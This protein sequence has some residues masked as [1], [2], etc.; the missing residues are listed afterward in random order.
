MPNEIM[1]NAVS[2]TDNSRILKKAFMIGPSKAVIQKGTIEVKPVSVAQNST[3]NQTNQTQNNNTENDDFSDEQGLD[4]DTDTNNS[5]YI[6]NNKYSIF[7]AYSNMNFLNIR[8]LINEADDN[9]QQNQTNN[10]TNDT[11]KGNFKVSSN[12][13]S[14]KVE[15][16]N[17]GFTEWT[18][19]FDARVNNADIENVLKLIK[20]KK[21]KQALQ[22]A[23][24]AIN[25][26]GDD[27]KK[28]DGFTIFS[29][30][31]Y[32]Y[33]KSIVKYPPSFIGHCRYAFDSGSVDNE[34]DDSSTT[35]C[36]AVA[37]INAYTTK[38]DDKTVIQTIYRVIGG[39]ENFTGGTVGKLGAV[40]KGA[41]VDMIRGDAERQREDDTTEQTASNI[42]SNFIH[43]KF[44]HYIGD[45]NNYADFL[46][47][48]KFIKE[49]C[50][51]GNLKIEGFKLGDVMF[52]SL[53]S[54]GNK[55]KNI[56]NQ[57]IFY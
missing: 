9:S 54:I 5:S 27:T 37:P 13:Y 43:K 7:E 49:Q 23:T 18:I 28:D 57:L 50:T 48:K 51:K 10:S 19:M 20:G 12:Y 2:G 40:T 46:A 55:F 25:T 35:V 31:T 53:A 14:I 1:L 6:R 52:N 26:E 30:R 32:I 22:A 39:V 45:Q 21:F 47:I 42:L 15:L 44:T 34:D 41:A 8:S 38:P 17:E 56:D 4:F 16:P 36:L 29:M 11:D 24:N 33:D 3:D